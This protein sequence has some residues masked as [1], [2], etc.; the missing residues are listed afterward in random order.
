L[1]LPVTGS[2]LGDKIIPFDTT[3]TLKI[4]FE[5][6]P[7]FTYKI[8]KMPEAISQNLEITLKVKQ[9]DATNYVLEKVSN[10]C[11]E[12]SVSGENKVNVLAPL[13]VED[14]EANTIFT[15]FPNPTSEDLT[16]ENHTNQ[17]IKTQLILRDLNGK[18]LLHKSLTITEK[19]QIS[20][21][22]FPSGTYFL[23]LKTATFKVSRKITKL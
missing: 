7:P 3:A 12:G 5:G 19:E 17:T 8:S 11:G 13:A 15:I 22:E 10:V 2:F 1:S 4:R 14:N 21:E 20:L 16:I 6:T 23:T 18:K 9:T